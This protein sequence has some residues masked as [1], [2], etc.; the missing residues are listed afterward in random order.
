MGTGGN[1]Y[2][3][4]GLSGGEDK[5][6]FW[7]VVAQ[8]T[9]S[10]PEDK[11]RYGVGYPLDIVVCSALGADM[12]DCVYPTRTARFG[13]ALV[14]E[15]VLKLKHNSMANDERP[16][17]PTC[18]CMVCKTYTRAYI[19]C[20]VTKDAMGSQ[21]LSYH[22]LA[23]MMRLSRNLH[24]S[25]V[26]GRF[27]EFVQEFLRAQK[28]HCVGAL[29][30]LF[31]TAGAL[32][33]ILTTGG[34]ILE[35]TITAGN[36][37]PTASLLSCS[38]R[39][40]LPVLHISLFFFSL[41][42]RL[43]VGFRKGGDDLI[44]K[45]FHYISR[46]QKVSH[47]MNIILCSLQITLPLLGSPTAGGRRRDEGG[48]GAATLLTSLSSSRRRCGL[49][50][51]RPPPL[52]GSPT[53]RGG[54]RG[55]GGEDAVA[56]PCC[57][58]SR[59]LLLPPSPLPGLAAADPC[60]RYLCPCCRRR[61]RLAAPLP[62]LLSVAWVAVEQEGGRAPPLPLFCHNSAMAATA[63]T[64][65]V[66]FGP[67]VVQDH[68]RND[69]LT[70]PTRFGDFPPVVESPYFLGV[71]PAALPTAAKAHKAKQT[72]EE[73]QAQEANLIQMFATY[74]INFVNTPTTGK[75]KRRKSSKKPTTRGIS[76]SGKT[77]RVG[78][79]QIRLDG[80][81]TLMIPERH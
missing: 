75:N 18:T 22:N 60:C 51:L 43:F 35:F 53:A 7:R 34:A 58:R 65:G 13:T 6:S 46:L 56:S 36:P 67:L 23:Y 54:R 9:A 70:T 37:V 17:D 42:V 26:E 12:Y 62:P 20:L 52:P 38:K 32:L 81:E 24:L 16:I 73:P 72:K 2:A 77:V 29:L 11:P 74:A 55:K 59:P 19:H 79:L 61:R 21:L 31:T 76:G 3:I 39:N 4:G 64:P 30:G 45:V 40:S 8:C 68:I 78:D 28:D 69:Y 71:I 48:E 14:P 50:L 49:H 15:G 66:L 25:I 63:Y 5:D 47:I 1:S 33:W 27:P 80:S 44:I 41:L 10:L 57:S